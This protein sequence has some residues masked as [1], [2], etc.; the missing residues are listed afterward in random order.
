MFTTRFAATI[1]STIGWPTIRAGRRAAA[2]RTLP[3]AIAIAILLAAP[4]LADPAAAREPPDSPERVEARLAEV[5]DEIRAI[6]E[7]LAAQRERRSDEQAALARAETELAELARTLRATRARI[8]SSDARR[9]E[10]AQ[11]ADVLHAEIGQLR[12]RLAEQ[13]QLAYRVGL[14][15]RLKTLLA[16]ED[17]ARIGRRLALHGYVGR[18]R[19]SAIDELRARRDELAALESEQKSIAGTLAR[20]AARQQQAVERRRE[21]NR[22]RRKA[23]ADLE[24]R[25]DS[26]AERLA[27]LR[28]AEADLESLLAQLSNALADIPPDVAVEPF[29]SYKGALPMPLD[30]P[31]AAGFSDRRAAG[32][33]WEG[34]LIPAEIGTPVSAVAYGR[35]AYADW[36]R[37]Y[38]M[39]LI[40]DHGDGFMTLYGR[41]QTLLAEVGDWVGPGDVIALAG[42]SGGGAEAG[43]YFQIR[44]GGRPVDP[45]GW[46]SRQ[47]R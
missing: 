25:I 37:G 9:R 35:V 1:G 32:A 30:G 33:A 22:A 38:G 34:W 2:A 24:S 28:E 31:V 36:L 39:M 29:A 14:K 46:I 4:P 5:R 44:R 26:Q 12:A 3:S 17:P 11:R 42:N 45:A 21:A 40:I 47:V 27:A 6:G 16:A 15:S 8:E 23:L 19:L 41:N 13:L 18:A 20:L 7:R 10:L 43:L